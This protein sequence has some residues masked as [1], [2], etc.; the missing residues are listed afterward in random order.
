MQFILGLVIGLIIGAIISYIKLK[1]GLQRTKELDEETQNLNQKLQVE[2]AKLQAQKN[3]ITS[4]IDELEKQATDAGQRLFKSK[5]ELAEAQFEQ[6]ME[7]LG[8]K[9]EQS[10]QEYQEQYKLFIAE[11]AQ[12][13]NEYISECSQKRVDLENEISNQ[14]SI[15]TAAIE[16]NKRAE[17]LKLQKD[18]Y[19]LNLSKQDID[20]IQLLREIIPHLRNPE[21]L[22][23]V[24]WKIYYEKPCTDLIGRVIGTSVLPKIGIY[25]ITNTL[26]GM[27][28]VG[29]SVDLAA[30][31]KQ[32]V[33]RGI[34]A[35]T[36]TRN[37]LYPAMMEI[38]VENF[39]FEIIE[40]CPKEKLNE[41]ELYWQDYFGAKE[42][43]YSIK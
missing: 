33:K 5:F 40:E 15:V 39:T 21:A 22:N 12:S 35:E 11:L 27:C 24:I 34:G 17:E 41:R 19:K 9:Y 38:G 42:F 43:G 25:K 1:P 3:E 20:E 13:M 4:S 23:K 37:K 36:S 26:N 8:Q 18:F 7:K 6:A 29:Q 10:E 31:W 30:R 2:N 14:R 32:H 16:A 28:Y